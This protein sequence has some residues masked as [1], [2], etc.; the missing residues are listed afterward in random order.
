MH[1]QH[2]KLGSASGIFRGRNTCQRSQQHFPSRLRLGK[3]DRNQVN[4]KHIAVGML[5]KHR[6]FVYAAHGPRTRRRD[7]VQLSH[8]GKGQSCK[9]R[10]RSLCVTAAKS[11]TL[12]FQTS[13]GT[14]TIGCESGD[15]LRD[16][17]L[18][19]KVDLY[20]TWGKI[21]TCGGNGQCGTCVVQVEA[22]LPYCFSDVLCAA[23]YSAVPGI[24][25]TLW[26]IDKLHYRF[27]MGMP[28]FQT[29][30]KLRRRNSKG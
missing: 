26:D 3:R 21:W 14:T 17:M 27:L 12:N 2:S 23:T 10:T 20:T 8:V 30:M 13:E 5:V 28:C 24:S 16:V 1:A 25:I 22:Y 4:R 29:R 11:V 9:H 18:E 6:P 19:E 15:I 7:A